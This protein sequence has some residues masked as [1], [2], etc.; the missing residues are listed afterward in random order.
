MKQVTE[1]EHAEACQRGR[2]GSG[3]AGAAEQVV[4]STASASQEAPPTSQV[5]DW[6]A[7]RDSVLTG[8]PERL[9]E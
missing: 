7:P 6:S 5:V 2:A 9:L 8:G 3:P 1:R 4:Q